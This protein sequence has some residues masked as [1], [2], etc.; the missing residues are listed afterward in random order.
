MTVAVNPVAAM[1]MDEALARVG[2]ELPRWR[3]LFAKALFSGR[4]RFDFYDVFA[5]YL[6]RSV[7]QPEALAEI[8][9]I[10]VEGRA[11]VLYWMRPLATA[12]PCWLF[13]ILDRGENF[14]V[15]MS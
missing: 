1:D 10:E 13:E 8:Y 2:A 7:R 4:E 11:P 15:V 6:D 3:V 12:I 9:A 5:T 14:G